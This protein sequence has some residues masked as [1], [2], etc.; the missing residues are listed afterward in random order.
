[1]LKTAICNVQL[2]LCC[3]SVHDVDMIGN[4][5]AYTFCRPYDWQLA[6][7]TV[8]VHVAMRVLTPPLRW[9]I[10]VPRV[11]WVHGIKSAVPKLL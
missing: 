11:M 6:T 1:M 5:Q 4:Q 8:I 9:Y 2:Y 3:Q 10:F 7:Y